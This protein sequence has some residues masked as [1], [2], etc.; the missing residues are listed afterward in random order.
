MLWVSA[1][2]ATVGVVLNWQEFTHLGALGL[3]LVGVATAWVF[4]PGEPTVALVVTPSRVAEGRTAVCELTVQNGY[5]PLL[6]PVLDVMVDGEP[7]VS[8]RLP[9]L[10]PLARH[11]EA[12]TIPARPR[13]VWAIGPITYDRSDVLGLVRR[14]IEVSPNAELWVRPRVV[15]LELLTSGASTDLEGVTSEQ[16]TMSDLAFHALREYRPGDDLRH[17]HWRSS[18]KADQL[19]VRQYH[20][21]RRGHVTVLVDHEAAFYPRP[22]DFELAV[23]VAASIA[24]RAVSDGLDVYLACGPVAGPHQAAEQVLDSACRFRQGPGEYGA[25]A[26]AAGRANPGTGLVVQV[27]GWRRTTGALRTFAQ[28][29][30]GEAH[31][32]VIRTDRA[33]PAGIADFPGGREI[34]IGR[35]S[36]LPS[37]MVASLR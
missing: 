5:R 34:R 9:V 24:L 7:G 37:L 15:R 30:N 6:H 35:L 32:V 21:T 36:Q 31:H 11:G 22:V 8:V 13:G 27:S 29:L 4:V 1:A 26:L 25:S 10:G 2:C 12:I 23:S 3:L 18:A 16:L 20:E 14:G 33:G 19:L 17:V 28:H